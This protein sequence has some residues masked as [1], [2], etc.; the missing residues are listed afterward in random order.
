[1]LDIQI[2]GLEPERNLKALI[3]G[4]PGTGKTLFSSTFPDPLF[5]A[6]EPGLLS[7]RKRRVPYQ[8]IKN[9]KE[10]DEIIRAC[11]QPEEVRESTFGI[12]VKTL[13]I[14]TVD[15]FQ[16]I[17]KRQKLSEIG[18]TTLDM[19]GWG[20]LGETMRS[21]LAAWQG[22]D[23][24]VVL[25]CHLKETKD[26]EI[27]KI[28]YVPNIEG[29][30]RDDLPAAFDI[31]GILEAS[32]TSVVSGT[33][34]EKKVTRVLKTA[35]DAYSG[36]LKDRS[37]SLPPE[38]PVN[39]ET[40]F[41]NLSELVFAD[42][43]DLDAMEEELRDKQKEITRA[44]H[45]AA[46]QVADAVAEQVESEKPEEAKPVKAS[47]T[48]DADE[49]QVN[50]V[51]FEELT[52]PF[53]LIEDEVKR[54][55]VK[56]DFVKQFGNPAMLPVSKFAD[57]KVWVDAAV[58]AAVGVDPTSDVSVD[59]VEEESPAQEPDPAPADEASQEEEVKPVAC[60]ESGCKVKDLKD[61]DLIELTTIQFGSPLCEKHFRAKTNA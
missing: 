3:C 2:T 25:T 46:Q 24:N 30:S 55:G 13:V 42:L 34:T 36:W 45:E 54:R 12:P 56:N 19:Q 4:D 6:C 53:T 58:R 11:R 22:L 9:A 37:G 43:A 10:M 31:A 32:T 18:K 33:G 48:V 51:Q 27:G 14:D 29:G 23:M 7:L 40:D 28:F 15:A 47:P 52:K 49:E 38:F 20:W 26:E 1:M 50:T 17:L 35:P 61:E 44:T 39:L 8:I 41:D 5:A 60:S 59:T 57:A 21:Y 16:K